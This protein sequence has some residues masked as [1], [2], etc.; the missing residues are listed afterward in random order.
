MGEDVHDHQKKKEVF[1][2][3]VKDVEATRRDRWREEERDTNSSIRRD[4]WRE[5]DKGLIDGRKVD[6]WT[7]S[8]GRHY[9]E[10]RRVP[11]ER[12]PDSGNRESS[13]DQRRESKWN[14]RWGPDNKEA[15]GLREKWSDFSKDDD[16]PIEKGP[17]GLAYHGKDERE[18]DHYRPWRPNSSQSRG[19][20]DPPHHLTMTPNKHTFTVSQGRGRGENAPT[21]SHG[22]G[23]IPSVG[24]SMNEVSSHI[25]SHSVL[26]EKVESAHDES[27]PLRYSRTKLLS[28]YRTT[29]MGYTSKYLEGVAQIPSLMQE[30]PL[31]PLA[32]CAP[33]AEELVSCCLNF[34][35][36]QLS[37]NQ[38]N[39]LLLIDHLERN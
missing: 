24:S 35:S 2:P 33:S 11:V 6:R 19:R 3:S 27:S 17:S 9:G 36:S 37:F 16:F 13:H 32:I 31:E 21:F 38:P 23:R 28:V 10:A 26:S 14:T 25:Q 12:F 8:A 29:D 34:F 39:I 22:R 18:G 30:E 1:R 15:D 4:R 5:G 20:M 7:D